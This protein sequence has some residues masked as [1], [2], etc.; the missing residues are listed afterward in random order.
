MATA[1]AAAAAAETL[2]ASHYNGSVYALSLQNTSLS[3]T[4]ELRTC[5]SMPSWL[6]LDARTET[7]YCADESGSLA[8]GTNGSLTAL[9]VNP[10]AEMVKTETLPGGVASLIYDDR[11]AI[12]HYEGSAVSTFSLPL[13]PSS[14][15]YQSFTY[16]LATPLFDPVRQDAP[17]PH[18][19]LFDPSGEFLLV[20]DLG[21]DVIHLFRRAEERL[22]ACPDL[23]VR[24]G[25]GPRHATF[26]RG[27]L[28]VS[29][30]LGRTVSVYAVHYGD[31]LS[32]QLI[33][34]ITPYPTALPS[35][36][37]PAEIRAREGKIYVSIR[38]DA[39]FA[40]MDSIVTLSGDDR[41]L[42]S[43]T[44]MTSSGGTVPRTFDIN[45]EGNLLAVGN[46]A[47]SCV[48]ILE[49]NVQTGE[50]GD[51]LASIQVGPEGVA[52][53]STGLS[54]VIWGINKI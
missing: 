25:D 31:C 37:T 16:E 21:A 34:E 10:L 24:R 11:I 54:S 23:P 52:G 29:N 20:P 13:L 43:F 6:T 8:Q 36:A 4:A 40:S 41:G 53:T 33:Q 39:A 30:E 32:I 35:G 42:L 28:Y 7:L 45:K 1:T 3:V 46:Q 9:S 2:Y 27:Y 17:H 38:S 47:S 15:S 51:V 19:V 18:D 44:A 48:A 49:R 26:S 50:L 12:A 22:E 5:G 14:S